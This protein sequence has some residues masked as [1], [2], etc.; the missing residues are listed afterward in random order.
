MCL[1]RQAVASITRNLEERGLVT[2]EGAKNDGRKM[3]IKITAE[4]LALVRQT[5]LA[6]ER[7][8]IHKVLES[9]ANEEEAGTIDRILTKVLSNLRRMR[10]SE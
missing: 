3:K 7:K 10:F 6:P 8:R 1:S 5:G 9:I 4:G 2:R